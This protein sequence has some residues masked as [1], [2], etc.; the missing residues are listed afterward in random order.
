M[1]ALMH[2]ASRGQTEVVRLL[3]PLEARLQD[4]RGWTALM[5]AVG[6]GHEECVG[7][8]LLERDLKD[9][10]GRTAEDVA[11]GLPDG[12]R[13]RITPLLRRKVQLPDL[14]EELLGYRMGNTVDILL[15]DAYRK[16][17]CTSVTDVL[18]S[19]HG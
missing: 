9:G 17:L 11:N 1:T 7:L 18:H 2:A 14:P 16:I 8:L 3:R 15:L 6:R 10:E 19:G 13:R 4:G 5:H 12:E